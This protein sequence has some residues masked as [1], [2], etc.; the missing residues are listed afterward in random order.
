M[1]N[2]VIQKLK[3]DASFEPRIIFDVGANI[4]Q[5]AR[6]FA[7]TWP[8]AYVISFEPIFESFTRLSQLSQKFKNFRAERIAMSSASGQMT[9]LSRGTS[10]VNR[11]LS[12]PSI[13]APPQSEALE[14]VDCDTI[15]NY[16]ANRDIDFIDFLK[17]D[18]EGHDLRVLSGSVGMLHERRIDYVSVEISLT[19][20]NRRHIAFDLALNFM[21]Q[22][23]YRVFG[24]FD[25]EQRDDKRGAAFGNTIF[26]RA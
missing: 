18:T 20:D 2:A 4:G 11:I 15:N 7:K 6:E 12:P 14:T 19:P 24:F 3:D 5:S 26:I 8:N 25:L 16:C 23:G 10:Q 1:R 22:F 17:I 9:M 21:G 13:L